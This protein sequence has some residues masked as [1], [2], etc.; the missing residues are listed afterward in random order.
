MGI[1]GEYHAN[2]NSYAQFIA[3][4]SACRSE[5]NPVI[6]EYNYSHDNQLCTTALLT[7]NA[8]SNT[9]DAQRSIIE[10]SS[11]KCISGASAVWVF[12][13]SEARK[14]REEKR[15]EGNGMDYK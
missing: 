9:R 12:D 11:S 10:R 1:A 3:S 2:I 7:N 6:I 14:R 15:R 13:S 4:A 8:H 5:S